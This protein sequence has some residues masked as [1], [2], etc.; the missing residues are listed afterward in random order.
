MSA[1]LRRLVARSRGELPA[2]APIVAPVFGGPSA[3]PEAEQAVGL[4]SSPFETSSPRASR[5]AA[6]PRPSAS[7]GEPWPPS[8]SLSERSSRSAPTDP[9]AV[10]AAMSPVHAPWGAA[11]VEPSGSVAPPRSSR[12]LAADAPVLPFSSQDPGRPAAEPSAERAWRGLE[13]GDLPPRGRAPEQSAG[14]PP[15]PPTGPSEPPASRAPRPAPP[16]ELPRA[17][18][19]TRQARRAAP[20]NL[21]SPWQPLPPPSPSRPAPALEAAAG[22]VPPIGGSPSPTGATRGEK[23][24][25]NE[26]FSTVER[27]AQESGALE[28]RPPPAR[29]SRAQD[30]GA[31]R[32]DPRPPAPPAPASP[33]KDMDI[34]ITIG[35]VEV[36]RPPSRPAAR[37]AAPRPR[38]PTMSLA[39]YLASRGGGRR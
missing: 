29:H 39:D 26:V 20:P 11:A 37:P 3:E 27:R 14:S 38:A 18:V 1:F 5:E 19:V 15:R 33:E 4:E 25:L 32:V 30:P 10:S 22:V 9:R 12:A 35:T 28:P 24:M 2:L 8:P 36:H 31:A 6:S 13:R 21:V 16:P 34:H 17:P 7:V 23:A